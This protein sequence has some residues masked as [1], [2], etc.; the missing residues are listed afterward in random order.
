MADRGFVGERIAPLHEAENLGVLALEMGSGA[1]WSPLGFRFSLRFCLWYSPPAKAG[2]RIEIITLE[3]IIE[4]VFKTRRSF[5]LKD[6][7]QSPSG[8]HSLLDTMFYGT[9]VPKKTMINHHC[10]PELLTP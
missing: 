8:I 9:G 5:Y 2:Q 7:R 1:R 10:R 3:E 4:I 6:P